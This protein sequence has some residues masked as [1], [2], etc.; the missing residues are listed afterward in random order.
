MKTT[1]YEIYKR[2]GEYVNKL[3]ESIFVPFRRRKLKLGQTKEYANGSK[4][5]YTSFGWVRY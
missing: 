4:E 1:D 2:H 5:V 3:A